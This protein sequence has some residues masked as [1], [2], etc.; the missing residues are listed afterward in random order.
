VGWCFY[1]YLSFNMLDDISTRQLHSN[2][3][4][5]LHCDFAY[6]WSRRIARSHISETCCVHVHCDQK[7]K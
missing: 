3:F 4:S 7:R 6:G 5:C 2:M 1:L